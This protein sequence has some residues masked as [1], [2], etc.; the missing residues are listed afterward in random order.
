ME[1]RASRACEGIAHKVAS[2]LKSASDDVLTALDG[3]T[4]S[5]GLAS[6]P[7]YAA[8]ATAR[9]PLYVG[10]GSVLGELRASEA[11]KAAF[12]ANKD[13]V[14]LVPVWN[15]GTNKFDMQAVPNRVGD[16]M[17]DYMAAQSVS[18][19][20]QGWFSGIFERPLLYSRASKLVRMEQGGNPWCETFNLL[21][22]DYSGKARI[23]SAG[24]AEN[25]D[26][27]DVQARS[28]FMTAP[29][30]NMFV[31]Y[32]V[33]AEEL[34]RAEDGASP[35]GKQ[36]MANKVLYADYVLQVASD[37]LTY[38]GNSDT[39]T[40]GLMK[41]VNAYGG[42]SIK[43]IV[44][45]AGTTKGSQIYQNMAAIITDYLTKNKNKMDELK[46][47]VSTYTWNKLT[48]IPYSDAYSAES[49]LAVFKRNFDAGLSENDRVPTVEFFPDPM[50]DKDSKLNPLGVDLTVISCPEIGLGPKN[51]KR[52]VVLQ[53]MPLK[54]FVYPVA[55]GQM[56]TQHRI[57][58]RY[59]GVFMPV[60]D[61]VSVISG[62]G[63]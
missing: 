25:F 15:S 44:D 51:E 63:Q 21:L 3:T 6:D 45:G 32:N 43:T 19:W 24:D 62:F 26:T 5:I 9:S 13:S 60:P 18:P 41:T 33:S 36:L 55:P 16:A 7:Q 20:N 57:L 17:P 49:P 38:F 39:G 52:P 56:V 34:A 53:G 47:A 11:M 10:D 4:L 46:V 54:R 8:P 23:N 28:G 27:A 48:S 35:F 22:A 30:I 1:I 37:M 2:F 59:A 31:T 14:N 29:V 50:L 58:R 40:D 61:A 42:A 12:A